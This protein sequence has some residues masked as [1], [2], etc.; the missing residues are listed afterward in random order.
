M[1]LR[2]VACRWGCWVF[3]ASKGSDGH[4]S[5][6]FGFAR[7]LSAALHGVWCPAQ[8]LVY[9]R[10]RTYHGRCSAATSTEVSNILG[11]TCNA[12]VASWFDRHGYVTFITCTWHARYPSYMSAGEGLGDARLPNTQTAF[13]GEQRSRLSPT[14]T[15][16]SSKPVCKHRRSQK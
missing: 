12:S 2:K 11:M 9:L 4:V 13:D 3:S 6:G 8:G 16:Q 14:Q 15:S 1:G 10:D 7:W 5:D